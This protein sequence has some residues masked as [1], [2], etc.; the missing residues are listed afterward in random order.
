MLLGVANE[1][2]T[3]PQSDWMPTMIGTSAMGC[4]ISFRC[5][6]RCRLPHFY[7]AAAGC[8]VSAG[9]YRRRGGPLGDRHRRDALCLAL[10]ND[11]PL[12][13]AAW[14]AIGTAIVAAAGA[15]LGAR[16]LRW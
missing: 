16:L 14:Y 10:Q 5:F 13:M 12:F 2:I 6:Q 7:R 3:L 11:S 1:L 4:M 8:A 9:A 15:L